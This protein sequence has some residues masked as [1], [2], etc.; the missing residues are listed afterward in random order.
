MQKK[1]GGRVKEKEMGGGVGGGKVCSLLIVKEFT[2]NQPYTQ[3]DRASL[4]RVAIPIDRSC[5]PKF[6]QRGIFL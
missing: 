4:L 1:E 3:T 5:N 6:F 2:L